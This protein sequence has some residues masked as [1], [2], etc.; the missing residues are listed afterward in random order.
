M[1]W[2]GDARWGSV[3]AAPGF[4]PGLEDPKSSVLP[5][6]NAATRPDWC[7]RTGSNRHE[8]CPSTVF[9]TAASACSATSASMERKTR[10][11]LATSSLA[12]RRSTTELLPR[13]N[14]CRRRDL[15]PH[16]LT[17]TTPSRWRVYQLPPL[18]HVRQSLAGVAGFEPATGGFGDH[19]STN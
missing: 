17:P 18:R 10:L 19:C 13:I 8:G 1:G 4:E 16:R 7:R 11:E 3:A 5:L 12:R 2:N 9:E 14:W 15:N 6:H